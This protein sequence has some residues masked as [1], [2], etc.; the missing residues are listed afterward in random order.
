MDVLILLIVLVVEEIILFELVFISE[1]LLCIEM[2]NETRAVVV[3][4][5]PATVPV[6]IDCDDH[7]F[8]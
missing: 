4:T 8:V 7:F 3:L 2:G 5:A 6:C 1:I